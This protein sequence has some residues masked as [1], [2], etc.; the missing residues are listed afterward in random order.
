[1]IDQLTR[2]PLTNGSLRLV[3]A[4]LLLLAGC[5][6]EGGDATVVRGTITYEGKPATH[7]AINIAQPGQRP[8]GGAINS[9]GTF[10]FEA[11]P[12]EYEV[13]IDVPPLIPEGAKEGDPLPKLEPRLIPEKYADFKSSGLTLSVGSESPQQQDFTLP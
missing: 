6:G 5:G 13:R 7:G 12:G 8:F 1:V 2:N 4:S 3:A 11:P 9:D 10:E